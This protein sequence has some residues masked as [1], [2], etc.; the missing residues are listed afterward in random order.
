VEY[1]KRFDD[2]VS[3][4]RYKYKS[5]HFG[6]FRIGMASLVEPWYYR[7]SNFQNWCTTQNSDMFTY[8]GCHYVDQVHMI[9]GL[10]PVQVSVYGIIESYP[11]GNKGYLWTDGR[12]IWENDACLSVINGMGYPNAG[13]GGNSQ[14]MWLFT[15]GIKDGGLIFH[16]DQYRGVKHS[17]IEKSTAPGE[18]YY[19]E[20]SPDYFQLIERGQDGLIPVGYGYTSIEALVQAVLRV[21]GSHEE[22]ENDENLKN[23]QKTIKTIDKEGFIA[24][25]A[26]SYYNELVIEA[27]RL[28]IQN[29]GRD[30]VIEYDASPRVR[31]KESSEYN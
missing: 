29:G 5:G 3:I 7:N 21:N 31:F 17:Y 13:P 24:T 6:E 30:V 20:P 27:A 16:D 18:T 28:S 9:T 11:N 25:P 14:G 15:Q 4:A 26:N 1:H 2:R 19:N 23:R 8:I 10:L 22:G 12:V